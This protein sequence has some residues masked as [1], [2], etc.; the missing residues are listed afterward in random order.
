MSPLFSDSFQMFNSNISC[1]IVVLICLFLSIF[2]FLDR[3]HIVKQPD[4]TPTEQVRLDQSILL[5]F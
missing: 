3:V 2:S 4:Y 1:F 5:L